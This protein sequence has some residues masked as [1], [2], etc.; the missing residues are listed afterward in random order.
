MPRSL[1]SSS[2]TIHHSFVGIRYDPIQFE[3]VTVS[4]NLPAES[5]SET[6]ARNHKSARYH[7]TKEC[8]MEY[9]D[10]LDA[11]GRTWQQ[12]NRILDARTRPKPNGEH[13]LRR[14][15]VAESYD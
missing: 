11:L 9:L 15:N 8:D 14:V 12:V 7:D 3:P 1:P 5:S 13:M 6:S 10:D 4:V 2:F